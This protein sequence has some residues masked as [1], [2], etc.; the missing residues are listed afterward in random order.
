MPSVVIFRRHF[1]FFDI[2]PFGFIN[3]SCNAF[4]VQY[5]LGIIPTQAVIEECMEKILIK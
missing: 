3:R 1:Y 2:W 5:L 4:T